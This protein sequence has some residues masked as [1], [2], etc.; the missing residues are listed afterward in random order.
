M[1]RKLSRAYATRLVATGRGKRR[2][3]LRALYTC[4]KHHHVAGSKFNPHIGMAKK[5]LDAKGDPVPAGN[6]A[7]NF[8]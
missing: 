6:S 2:S 7:F 1:G 3:A 4:Y 5:I 8:I